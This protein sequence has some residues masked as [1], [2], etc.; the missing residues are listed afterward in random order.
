MR[1]ASPSTWRNTPII[2]TEQRTTQ[3][4]EEPNGR[5]SGQRETRRC[6]RTRADRRFSSPHRRAQAQRSHHDLWRARHP[7]HGFRPHGAGL[8]H[9]RAVI[10]PRA[11]C[12]LC[13]RDRGLPHQ[14]A[15]RLSHRVG[16]RLPQ[17][18]HCACSRH[19][20]LLPDDPDVG[21]VGARGRRLA[22]GRLRGDGP[23]RHR[24]AAVQGGVPRAARARHRHRARARHPRRGV[25]SSGRRLS[26]SAR[27][28]VRPGDGRGRRPEVANQS[29]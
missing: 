12:R 8:G 19:H 21:I 26:R 2:W 16:A 15:G 11:E 9:S 1:W 7:D 27:K 3:A 20:Q 10:P 4:T 6:S 18:A 24:Q 28:T 13:G 14:E 17:R 5:R 29:H 23:A 25:G 22:A